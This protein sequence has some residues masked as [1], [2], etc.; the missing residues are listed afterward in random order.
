MSDEEKYD[1]DFLESLKEENSIQTGSQDS[2]GKGILKAYEEHKKAESK[3]NQRPISSYHNNNQ[4]N[5]LNKEDLISSSKQKPQS[6][7]PI[8]SNNSNINKSKSSSSKSEKEC[9]KN[10]EEIIT[11]LKQFIEKYHIK[12]SDF[13][14][15]ENLFLSF[16]DFKS[17]LHSIHY[18]IPKEY[19]RVLFN[20]NN[21]GAIDDYI[22]MAKFLKYVYDESEESSSIVSQSNLSSLHSIQ[23]KEQK[24]PYS[25]KKID[26]FE[27][28]KNIYMMKVKNQ[29][30]LNQI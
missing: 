18:M 29:V 4:A 3:I 21:E 30:I 26:K 25:N 11:D 16:E 8:S 14:D 6:A 1:D 22:S 9:D 17:Q 15:N 28:E 24:R 20:N 27:K 19:V 13:I 12:K 5:N 2:F 7:H 23:S 10:F